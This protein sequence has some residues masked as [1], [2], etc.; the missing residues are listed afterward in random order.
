MEAIKA[1]GGKIRFVNP[2]VTESSTP[3]TGDTLL[4]KPGADVYFL[5]ALLNEIEE[6]GGLDQE[7]IAQWG[8]DADKALE[9][10]S[11]YPAERVVDVTG[12]S[13]EEIKQSAADFVAA[14]GAGIYVSVGVNQGRQGILA[15][16]LA[17]LIV[18]LTGNLGKKGGM[19]KPTGLADVFQPSPLNQIKVDTSLGEISYSAP[20][21][22]PM[23]M[24]AMSELIENGDIKALINIAGNPLLSAGGEDKLRA[25]LGKLDLIVS[26]DIQRNSTTEMSDYI[27][28]G[29]DFL[30]RADIGMVS[31]GVQPTPYVHYTDA[32]V[33]PKFERR[34]DW[35]ILLDIAKEMGLFPGEEPDGWGIINKMLSMRGLSIEKLSKLEHQTQFFEPTPI[36]DVYQK[37]LKHEDGKIHCYPSEFV[38]A[39][40]FERCDT[41]FQE[42][43]SEPSGSLKMI[44]MRTPYMHNTWY[45]NMKKFRRGAQSINPLHMNSSDAERLKL[46]DGEKIRVFNQYGSIESQL[47]I[48]DDLRP[49]AVAMAHGYGKGRAGMRV[50][51]SNPGANANQLVPDTMDTVEPLSNM[52]WI[53]AYPVEVE[54]LVQSSV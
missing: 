33:E 3:E 29:T 2:R 35:K 31:S 8:I 51:E 12:I 11:Q 18:F 48:D 30:E 17:D 22:I 21:P 54:S 38:E 42:L 20:G 16:W 4:I 53:G 46:T 44:S 37:C 26:L 5:A 39:G 15:A 40:L 52:S 27:L 1:R 28:P 34:D 14:N 32:V 10:A 25:A 36:D 6:I 50:A 47:C 24:V 9:F 13:A 23:P 19:Y 49:G 45:A 7:R 41:I 43:Q